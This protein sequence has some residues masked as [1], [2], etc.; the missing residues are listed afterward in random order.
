MRQR[1]D[2]I[3]LLESDDMVFGHYVEESMKYIDLFDSSK[4]FNDVNEVIEAYNVYQLLSH[5]HLK[6]EFVKAYATKIK[7]LMPIVAKFFKSISDDNFLKICDEVD[8]EYVDEFWLL[9]DKFKVYEQISEEKFAEYINNPHTTLHYILKEKRIVEHYDDVLADC[10]RN[11]DQTAEIIIHN[12][13]E[14]QGNRDKCYLPNSLK[15]FEYEGIL[16]KYVHSFH[17]GLGSLRVIE[18]FQSTSECPVSDKLR[19]EARKRQKE[20][21]TDGSATVFNSHMGI[22][23]SFRDVAELVTVENTPE[24]HLFIYDRQWLK[25]NLDYPTLLNNFIYMFGFVDMEFRS[26]FPSISSKLGVFERVMGVKGIKEYQTGSSFTFYNMKT[27]A[28]MHGYIEE[29]GRNNIRFENIIKWFF[30]EYL[31]EEF[32]VKGFSFA[33]SSKDSSYLEMCRNIA[34]EMDGVLKQY[35]LYAE[36]GEI[37]REL[38]EMSSR[39]VE[40]ES[41]PSLRNKKYAYM[42]SNEIKQEMFYLFSD[43]CLL[44]YV[45]RIGEKYE[46]LYDLLIKEE[47]HLS[48]YTRQDKLYQ[49]NWLIQRNTLYVE[50][51]VLKINLQRAFILKD[52][53]EH[54]V[55]CP[56]YYPSYLKELLTEMNLVGDIYFTN[57]FLSIPESD[58]L[59]YVLNK[60]QY[61]NGMDLR[62]RYIHSTYPENEE[63]HKRN[64]VELMK[65]MVLIIIKINEEFSVKS[66][67]KNA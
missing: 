17:P 18:M 14:K 58:Y 47:L 23:V 36:N 15:P 55:I 20:M 8:I 65:I 44:S 54:E 67:M 62:N 4:E 48:D 40:F 29:L 11:S 38:L 60:S 25:Q 57:T 41:L 10:L 52:L 2:G 3:K 56:D 39:S 31:V 5:K 34:S 46:C 66:E 30:E 33:T 24:G 1:Y 35:R 21:L 51:G 37:D 28:D 7:V 19:L 22:G 12:H 50:D 59:N 42:N 26:V 63:L 43:Q 64:Y 13:M 6:E 45:K 61:S 32:N 9:F 53:Y 16:R 49:I 27:S